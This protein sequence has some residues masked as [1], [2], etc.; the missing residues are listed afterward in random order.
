MADLDRFHAGQRET[1]KTAMN[2]LRSGRK[3]S[4]W[5]WFVFPQL[6]G[7]GS[8]SMAQRYA[9]AD[10]AEARAYL[11]DDVLSQRLL[12][13]ISAAYEQVV[14]KKTPVETLMGSHI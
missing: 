7:L 4:H 3:R 12:D 8:S 2:E 1:F 6:G 5:I 9:I 14:V 11:A 13:A 10:A